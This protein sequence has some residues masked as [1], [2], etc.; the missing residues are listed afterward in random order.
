MPLYTLQPSA[1]LSIGIDWLSR[2]KPKLQRI[3]RK[4]AVAGLY[5]PATAQPML[6]RGHSGDREARYLRALK[7]AT[8]GRPLNDSPHSTIRIPHSTFAIRLRH[9]ISPSPARPNAARAS[10]L[11]SGTADASAASS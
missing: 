4:K 2:L 7:T 10:V 11:G 8:G 1:A 6:P 3:R 5:K 9:A